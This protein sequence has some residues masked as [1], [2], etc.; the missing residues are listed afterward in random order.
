MLKKFVAC[1]L[2]VVLVSG[3]AGCSGNASGQG[4]S[5]AG[6]AAGGTI[7]IGF[8]GPLRGANQ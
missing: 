1:A 4:G 8:I 7:K 3:F 6:G 5:M 2:S